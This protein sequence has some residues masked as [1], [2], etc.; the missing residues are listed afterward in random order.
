MS[1]S[2]DEL[3]G[4]PKG[5]YV[6]FF[7]EMWE[8]FSYYGMRALLVLYMTKA[9]QYADDF[10]QGTYG[11]Y[12]GFVYATP[13][14]GGALADRVLGARKAIILG[15]ILMSFGHFIMAIEDPIF[16]YGAMSLIIAGNGF[17]KP[18]ISTLVGSL[19]EKNDLRRDGAFTIF[20]MGINLGAWAAPLACGYL[21]E[22]KDWGWHWGFGLAGVGMVFGLSVFLWGQRYLGNAGLPPNPKAPGQSLGVARSKTITI[23]FCIAAF[24]PIAAILL[25]HPNLVEMS[26]YILGPVVLLYVFFEAM[27]SPAEERGRIFVLTILIFFSVTFWACFEQAGSS[28]TLFADRHMDRRIFGWEIPTSWLQSVNPMFILILAIPFSYLWTRLGRANRDPSASFKFSLG[29]IQL[30]AGFIAMVI[31]AK[32]AA[33]GSM[34]SLWWQI[35]AYFLHTTGEL[36]LSPVG[37]STVTRMAPVRLVGLMMG[38]WFLSNAF[39][40]VLSGVIARLTS[41]EDGSYVEVYSMVVYCA[42]GVGVLLL[43]LTP[44]LNKLGTDPK[45]LAQAAGRQQ[46]K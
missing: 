21:G 2:Q 40:G 25:K 17:F 36:C 28:F 20:Y 23:Y 18:N 43:V 16:F 8:R 41:G 26:V 22:H 15:G 42:I 34:T 5:L 11:A 31:A 1:K 13:I 33:N 30:G 37:L 39:A 45:M 38:L 10:A 19:Y 44:L 9:L 7:A 29:L 32:E 3:F 12:I 4:H 6:L 24:L 46:G 14:I 35:L 27:R